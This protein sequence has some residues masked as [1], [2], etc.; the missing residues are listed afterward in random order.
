MA[1]SPLRQPVIADGDVTSQSEPSSG[2]QGTAHGYTDGGPAMSW[3][4][5]TQNPQPVTMITTR[6]GA[7]TNFRNRNTI[8]SRR[9]VACIEASFIRTPACGVV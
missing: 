3:Y 8:H 6:V 2:G 7:R 9:F 5:Q 4:L 1:A